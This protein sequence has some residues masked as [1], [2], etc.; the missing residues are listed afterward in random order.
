MIFIEFLL[1]PFSVLKFLVTTYSL[2]SL[3]NFINFFVFLSLEMNQLREIEPK[4]YRR[5]QYPQVRV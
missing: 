3:P 2:Q 5:G 4:G 1:H